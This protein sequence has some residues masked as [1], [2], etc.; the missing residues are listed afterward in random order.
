MSTVMLPLSVHGVKC[1]YTADDL[2]EMNESEIK[3]ERKIIEKLI[4][5]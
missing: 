3:F 2:P 1:S 4:S 5:I